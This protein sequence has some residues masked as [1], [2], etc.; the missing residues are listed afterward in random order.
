MTDLK[1]AVRTLLRAPFITAVAVVSLA[2]GIGANAAL[3]S[4]SVLKAR[5]SP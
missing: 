5:F 2:V 1:L 3:Y 4:P